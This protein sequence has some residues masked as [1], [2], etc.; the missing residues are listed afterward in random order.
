MS[1]EMTLVPAPQTWA[2]E[3]YD[4]R[5]RFSKFREPDPEKLVEK[6]AFGEPPPEDTQFASQYIG[7]Y[8][9]RLRDFVTSY[10]S[11]FRSR[12]ATTRR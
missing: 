11:T 2:N 5:A 6:F 3:V 7:N 9:K 4:D 10:P 12:K 1:N 8:V